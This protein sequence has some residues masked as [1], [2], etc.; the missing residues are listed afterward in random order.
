MTFTGLRK[1]AGIACWVFVALVALAWADFVYAQMNDDDSPSRSS[2][3]SRSSGFDDDDDDFEDDDDSDSDRRSSRSRSSRASSSR[4]GSRDSSRSSR[5]SRRSSGSR[6]GGRSS[7]YAP[8]AV[9]FG[10]S[11]ERSGVRPRGTLLSVEAFEDL[12]CTPAT[13]TIGGTTY[14]RC[15]GVWYNQ[16]NHEGWVVYS[17][18]YPPAGL[19]V[20]SLPRGHETIRAGDKTLYATGDAFYEAASDG[21]NRYVVVEP[22]PGLTLD[23]LPAKAKEG[24]PVQSGRHTYYRYLGVFYREEDSTGRTRYVASPNPFMP[25]PSVAATTATGAAGAAPPPAQ[26]SLPPPATGTITYR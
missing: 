7:N 12:P 25:P 23:R 26:A 9:V 15:G 4:S 20:D 19:G 13:T 21:R 17:E 10:Q 6:G 3:S 8:P 2:R 16:V 22:T 5:S 18:I 14:Y 1:V 24:I 11:Y